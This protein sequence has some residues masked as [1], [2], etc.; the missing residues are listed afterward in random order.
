[1]KKQHT[2]VG[3]FNSNKDFGRNT[4]SQKYQPK[5]T[6]ILFPS[7]KIIIQITS[8]ITRAPIPGKMAHR[9]IQKTL[10]NTCKP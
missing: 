2:L 4:G 7:T 8:N 1:M 9:E 5:Y 3:I 10:D 6:K